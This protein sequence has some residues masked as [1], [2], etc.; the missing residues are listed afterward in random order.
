M[1]KLSDD[2]LGE[3]WHL[4]WPSPVTRVLVFD[5]RQVKRDLQQVCYSSDTQSVTIDMSVIYHIN[6]AKLV[7]LYRAWKVATPESVFD[8]L[9]VKQ[10]QEAVERATTKQTAEST[11]RQRD[12]LHREVMPY[13]RETIS[14][15]VTIDSIVF[16]NTELT[17]KLEA[18]I[19]EKQVKQQEALAKQYE[20]DKAKKDA[21]IVEAK[22]R[23]EASAIE[24]RAIVLQKYP[25]VIL[26]ELIQKWDGEA[27]SYLGLGSSNLS[28]LLPGVK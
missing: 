14:N 11:I 24:M 15:M 5:T 9:V 12:I 21:E 25:S 17:K 8:T 13:L 1:G 4:T 23:G 19:E 26:L 7:D 28:T 16:S 3:G 27:P 22:A 2:T 18:A 20:L 10:M 6:E